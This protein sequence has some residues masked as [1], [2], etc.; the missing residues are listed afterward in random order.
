[1]KWF[2]IGPGQYGAPQGQGRTR[3]N[4]E[5][6]ARDRFAR[7]TQQQLTAGRCGG[8][9]GQIFEVGNMIARSKQE[10]Q[11][12]RGPAQLRSHGAGN[13]GEG[14]SGI[15]GLRTMGRIGHSEQPYTGWLNRPGQVSYVADSNYVLRVVQVRREEARCARVH[16]PIG[17]GFN[18]VPRPPKKPSGWRTEAQRRA[19]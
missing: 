16:P 15:L 11:V 2:E 14:A 3:L 7:A 8:P 5:T 6:S 19:N 4:F 17:G 10:R 13:F 18:K 9:P 1:M 12:G